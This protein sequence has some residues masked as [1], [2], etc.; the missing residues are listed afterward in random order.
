[1]KKI[2]SIIIIN[3]LLIVIDSPVNNRENGIKY[4]KT[5]ID[6]IQSYL[7]SKK[8]ISL[9]K[10]KK[11][12]NNEGIFKCSVEINAIGTVRAVYKEIR[13][14]LT[15]KS[16]LNLSFIRLAFIQSGKL[17]SLISNFDPI[18]CAHA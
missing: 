16:V 17:K 9:L 14:L 2:F 6:V 10:P 15:G 7:E 8:T 13:E 11:K 3:F 18:L 12:K 4:F 5:K 1:M